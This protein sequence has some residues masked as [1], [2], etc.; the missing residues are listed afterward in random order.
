MESFWQDVRQGLRILAKNRG[1]TTVAIVTLALGIGANTAIFSVVNAVLLRP[2][3]YPGADQLVRVAEQGNIARLGGG[4][5]APRAIVTSTTFQDWRDSTR[6]L[7]GLAAYQA[8]SYT[9]TGP[10]RADPAARHG[11]LDDDVSDASVSR[12]RGGSLRRTRKS[13]APIRSPSSAI[14]CGRAGS[15]A[16][17][18][19]S[20]RRSRST[21]GRSQSS[22]SCRPASTFRIVT[23]RS[24]RR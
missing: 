12:R 24:G 21:I 19:S 16:A 8:R 3:P 5:G 22:G 17:P 10:R 1:F 7:D 4:R 13:R 14:G 11:C 23:P 2:L 6:T 15:T 20:A 9:L 18:T